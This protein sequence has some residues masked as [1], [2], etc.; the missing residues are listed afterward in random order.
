MIQA[1]S[2]CPEVGRPS[3]SHARDAAAMCRQ[4]GMNFRFSPS[5]LSAPSVASCAGTCLQKYSSVGLTNSWF[6]SSGSEADKDYRL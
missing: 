1:C 6:T 5:P 2:K 3:S 4:D